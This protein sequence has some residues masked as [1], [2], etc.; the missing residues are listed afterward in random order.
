M[1]LLGGGG[2]NC[3]SS[4]RR[5]QEHHLAGRGGDILTD[6]KTIR[7]L[8]NGQFAAAAF[9]VGDQIVESL[10]Q[11]FA[12]RCQGGAHHFGI[13]EKEI[14]GRESVREL[15]GVEFHPLA[16]LFRNVVQ[17]GN[18]ALHR[19]GR[20]QIG[21]LDKIEDFVL[22]PFRIAKAPVARRGRDHRR[23]GLIAQHSAGGG[24]PQAHPV[25]PQLR[26]RL[27]HGFAIGAHGLEQREE[28]GRNIQRIARPGIFPRGPALEKIPDQPLALPPRPEPCCGQ[29]FFAVEIRQ[30]VGQGGGHRFGLRRGLLLSH[31]G[32]M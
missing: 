13:G 16:L 18:H 12:V 22:L 15:A 5:L 7:R 14:G 10:H 31:H 26:L 19:A 8:T 23:G 3:S 25:A 30:A 27:H 9:D 20:Q 21:L 4:I 6:Y 29:I 24:F 1:D 17:I 11:I 2:L 28:S 32:T